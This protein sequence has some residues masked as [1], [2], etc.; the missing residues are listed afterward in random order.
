VAIIG[1]LRSLADSEQRRLVALLVIRR[2]QG[3]V[4]RIRPFWVVNALHVVAD[5]DVVTEIAALPEVAEI[6]PNASVQAPSAPASASGP[7]WNVARVKAPDL[8]GLGY[9]G[10]GVVVANMDTG[11]DATHPDLAARWRGGTNSWYDPNGQHP[12]TPTDVSGHGTWTMGAMVGG[13]AGGSAVGIAPDARWIAVK[14]FNDRGTATT[15]GIHAGF[16]WLLDPDGN[17]A[18]DDAPDVLDDSWTMSAACDLTFQP[19]LSALRATGILPVF[20]AGNSGPAPATSMSP[21]NNPEAFAVGGTDDADAIDGGSSRGPSACGQATYPQLVAPGVNVRTTDLYGFYTNVTG[22]SIAA[23]HAAGALALLL[24]AFPGL[25]PERQAAALQQGAA[26]LGAL[27][28]DD[29]FGSGRLDS[30]ASY[31]WLSTAPDFSLTATPASATTSAGGSVTYTIAVQALNGFTG[32]VALSLHGPASA[33]FSP[34]TVAG[35]AGSAQLTITTAASLAPGTYAL[36]ITG[37]SGTSTRST[38]VSLV[39]P[40]P[41]DFSLTATPASRTTSAGGSATYTVSTSAVGGFSGDV[42]LSLSGSGSASGSFA[43]A[44]IAGGSGASELTV[45]TAASIAPGKYPLTITAT[46]GSLTHS[47]VVTLIVPDFSLAASPATRS[48]TPGTAATYTVSVGAVNGFTGS[49]ALSLSGLTQ[50]TW[51]F[52]PASVSNAGTSQLTVTPTAAGTYTLTVTGTSGSIVHTAK[53]TLVVA[54]P[55]DFG[56]TA[57]PASATVVAGQNAAYTVA[58]SS[59]G[60]FAGSV[61]LSVSGLPSQASA[62]FA[63]NP[64][65]APGSSTLTVRTSRLTTRGTF[66]LTITGRGGSLSHATTVT[67]AVRS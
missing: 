20:A 51:S 16:Q 2:L 40:Q 44:A 24:G 3:R 22:T 35:G 62:S 8:W 29:V 26:D 30:L 10:Q 46:S 21:A 52:A 47:A 64:L 33:S 1:A 37:T 34:A 43:P 6:K 53:V 25:D 12:S 41:P 60:G 18:T 55:G 38:R 45:T 39:I 5:P 14:I 15:A 28:P 31:T 7:E 19:D 50:G 54:A 11:V 42:A 27:G 48:T 58:V 13:D 65:A 32:D 49:V 63:P 23:P 59:S 66:T 67:L 17:P 36:T 61:S 4:S 56:L 57:T 9:H